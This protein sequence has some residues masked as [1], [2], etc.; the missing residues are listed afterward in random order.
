MCNAICIENKIQPTLS[1]LLNAGA[2]VA[3]SL[4]DN[5]GR[6]KL[7]MGSYGGMV[8]NFVPG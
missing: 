1:D 4:M 5:Q 8:I 6:R 7:L 2:V 3:L